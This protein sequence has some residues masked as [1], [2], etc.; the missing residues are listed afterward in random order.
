[1]V[2]NGGKQVIFDALMATVDEG[3]EVVI[4]APYWAAYR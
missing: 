1:M 4:P 3:D 2:A